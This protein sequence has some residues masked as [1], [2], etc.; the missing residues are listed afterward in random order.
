MLRDEGAMPCF[1]LSPKWAHWYEF[2][3]GGND[4][5]WQG[6]G[7]LSDEGECKLALQDRKDLDNNAYDSFTG[8]Q[9]EQL[10]CSNGS[11]LQL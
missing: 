7:A 5:Q 9:R 8:K 3:E 6:Q 2:S 11:Q 10:G 4:V 1:V